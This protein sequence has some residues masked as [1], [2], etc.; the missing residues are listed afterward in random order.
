MIVCNINEG[1]KENKASSETEKEERVCLERFAQKPRLNEVI[2][3]TKGRTM[4]L[5][6]DSINFFAGYVNTLCP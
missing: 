2:I 4:V 5:Q 6:N 1:A 3:R